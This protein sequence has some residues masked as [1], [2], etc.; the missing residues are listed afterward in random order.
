MS[1]LNYSIES[2]VTDSE[3]TVTGVILVADNGDR[4]YLTMEEYR[5]F[6]RLRSEKS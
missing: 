5:K 6:T 1:K 4:E 2:W 3:G